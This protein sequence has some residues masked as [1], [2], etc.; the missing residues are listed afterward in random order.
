MRNK[1]KVRKAMEELRLNTEP[2][3]HSWTQS[4]EQCWC[5]KEIAKQAG[6]TV[7]QTRDALYQMRGW[8]WK[9]SRG[10]CGRV[11]NHYGHNR[12][13][14]KTDRNW[15]V[16]ECW[17][18][19]PEY[20]KELSEEAH[21]ILS[22]VLLRCQDEG[23][24]Y[25]IKKVTARSDDP[26]DLEIEG[27]Q[28]ASPYSDG[29]YTPTNFLAWLPLMAIH[30]LMDWTEMEFARELDYPFMAMEGDWS[31]VRDT[32]P[33]KIKRL[34]KIHIQD[35]HPLPSDPGDPE[36]EE[37]VWSIDSDGN[38]FFIPLLYGCIGI[39]KAGK[40]W[41]VGLEGENATLDNKKVN[42][43]ELDHFLQYIEEKHIREIPSV[44]T[45]GGVGIHDEEWNM[46]IGAACYTDPAEALEYLKSAV[47]H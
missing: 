9:T 6:L 32:D 4:S 21:S 24:R 5:V 44:E 42:F 30:N 36:D 7:D 15:Q 26:I 23:Y 12:W 27:V 29:D 47:A 3:C 38:K 19:V 35:G 46:V 17:D 37:G 39:Y 8:Y 14:H 2:N 16:S 40:V 25:E 1:D 22:K 41:E 45:H 20:L 18:T 28:H 10:H 11:V 31:G 13:L 34:F 33:E 43:A